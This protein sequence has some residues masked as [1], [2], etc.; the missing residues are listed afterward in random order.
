MG[1]ETAMPNKIWV[2]SSNDIANVRII[3]KNGCAV[4]MLRFMI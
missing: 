2:D 1:R 4:L 3:S